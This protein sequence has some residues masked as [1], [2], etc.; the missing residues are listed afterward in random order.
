MRKA[1]QSWHAGSHWIALFIIVS[2]GI[3]SEVLCEIRSSVWYVPIVERCMMFE[4]AEKTQGLEM[5]NCL[6]DMHDVC[7]RLCA[8]IYIYRLEAK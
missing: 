5:N 7:S 8:R 4:Y 2:V 1:K 3:T 6:S